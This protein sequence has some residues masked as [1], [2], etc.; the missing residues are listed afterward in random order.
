MLSIPVFVLGLVTGS[1]LNVCIYRM[2]RKKSIIT[3]RSH[4]PRCGKTIGWFD[5]IPLLSYIGLR[6]KCRFCK[7]KISP[8]YFTVELLTGLVFLSF[9]NHFGLS[10]VFV[11][12][13]A[14]AC[15]LIVATF[16]DF[17]IR[18][19]PDEIT[20]PGMILGLILSFA[21]PQLMGKDVRFAAFIDSFVGLLTGGASIYLLSMFGTVVFRKKLKELGEESAM[22]GGDVK[23]LAMIGAYL[24]WKLA[25]LVFFLAPF[26]G[27]IVGIVLKIK[28]DTHI[29][30]YGPYLSLA[31]IIAILW[32]NKILS[33]IIF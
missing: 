33:W 26:F 25:L 28:N 2:P 6:G 31:A 23:L 3:P 15:A 10:A 27:S 32:G 9:F 19:I 21:F 4:C 30:P 29:I 13:T 14:L 17:K 24:G 5:N 7:E 11:V 16:I 18:E 12:Y 20:I 22:G 1:L 8:L